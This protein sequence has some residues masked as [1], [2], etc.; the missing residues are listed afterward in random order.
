MGV[1]MKRWSD[2]MHGIIAKS[3]SGTTVRNPKG[4]QD[5]LDLGI[6]AACP[7]WV[8]MDLGQSHSS[9]PLDFPGVVT[10][11]GPYLLLCCSWK[12]E[13]VTKAPGICPKSPCLLLSTRNRHF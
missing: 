6:S 9:K 4:F 5:S 12:K 7:V 11:M 10:E 2:V 3:V 13:S 1:T 8:L